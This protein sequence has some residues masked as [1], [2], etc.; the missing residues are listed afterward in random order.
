[1]VYKSKSLLKTVVP[2]VSFDVSAFPSKHLA[3]SNYA[4]INE[5]VAMNYH[6]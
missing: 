6:C 2:V 3:V 4:I 5:F 1:M